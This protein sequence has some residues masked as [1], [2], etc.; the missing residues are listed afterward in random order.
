[1]L[2]DQHNLTMAKLAT[3]LIFQLLQPERWLLAH[4]GILMDL[5]ASSFVRNSSLLTAKS[6]DFVVGT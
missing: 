1:M 4:T 6:V 2:S 5:P 3:G